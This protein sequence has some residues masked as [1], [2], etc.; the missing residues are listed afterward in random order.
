MVPE[1]QSEIDRN[2]LG[3]FLPFYPTIDPETKN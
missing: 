3:H 1:L 2:F